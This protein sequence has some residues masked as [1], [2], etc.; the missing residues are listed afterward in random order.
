MAGIVTPL[1]TRVGTSGSRPDA[2]K[3]ATLR[4]FL[5]AAANDFIAL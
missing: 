4:D 5:R 1:V 2:R 3:M